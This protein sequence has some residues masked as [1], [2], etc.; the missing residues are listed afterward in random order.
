MRRLHGSEISSGVGDLFSRVVTPS[1][2]GWWD[3]TSVRLEPNVRDLRSPYL[4]NGDR[5]V[6]VSMDELYRA[7]GYLPLMCPENSNIVGT[8]AVMHEAWVQVF[9]KRGGVCL[10]QAVESRHLDV[11]RIIQES[12]S[13]PQEREEIGVSFTD[14]ILSLSD[15]YGCQGEHSGPCPPT[16]ERTRSLIAPDG[17]INATLLKKLRDLGVASSDG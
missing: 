16:R 11:L 15:T 10:F 9:W 1:A 7:A 3:I 2:E 14:T 17:A 13:F 4:C 6:A 8:I 5:R 12:M